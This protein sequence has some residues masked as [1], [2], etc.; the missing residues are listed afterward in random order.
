MN[1][2]IRRSAIEGKAITVVPVTGYPVEVVREK[3]PGKVFLASLGGG[4]AGGVVVALMEQAKTDAY[5]T[6]LIYHLNHEHCGC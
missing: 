6:N 1:K 3:H 2:P 4:V 5:R